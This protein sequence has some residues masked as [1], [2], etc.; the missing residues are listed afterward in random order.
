MTG[1]E[2]VQRLEEMRVRGDGRDAILQHAVKLLH[3]SSPRFDWTGI[4]ELRGDVLEVGPFAGAPT[5]HRRIP[6][7]RGVCGTAV[8]EARNINVPDVAALTNY[9]ACS[10]AT[11]SELV[12]LIRRG[13][14]IFGQVDID[15]HTRD[16]F[17]P[18]DERR[19]QEVAD[20]L[21]G[22]YP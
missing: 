7:G 16:A 2:I 3:E 20:F 8:A 1:Q 17:G 18:G 14:R 22:L 6:V 19:V 9:L 5:E 4:Y 12:V 10:V 13:S 21:A 11:K 15:S